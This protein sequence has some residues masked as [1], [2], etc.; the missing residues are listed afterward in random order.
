MVIK[1][2]KVIVRNANLLAR[3]KDLEILRAQVAT[4][5]NTRVDNI[6]F[7]YEET[8]IKTKLSKVNL[9]SKKRF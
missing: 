4:V 7:T 2:D 1:I 6:L 9:N 3:E 5:F 8:D